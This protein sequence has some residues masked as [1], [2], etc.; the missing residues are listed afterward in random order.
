MY[1]RMN[2]NENDVQREP[3]MGTKT[4]VTARM[5][6]FETVLVMSVLARFAEILYSEFIFVIQ[7][8]ILLAKYLGVTKS[9]CQST[10]CKS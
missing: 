3:R 6:F 9:G 4:F 7:L 8:K 2:S 10:K 5:L 1:V